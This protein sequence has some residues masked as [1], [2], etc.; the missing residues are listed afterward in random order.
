MTIYIGSDHRGFAI[1]ANTIQ[2]LLKAGH[3]VVDVGPYIYN[4]NDDYVGYAIK[5]S[6]SVQNNSES[7][8]ILI[9]GSGVGMYIV[10]NK[11]KGIRAAESRSKAEAIHDRAHHNSNILVLGQESIDNSQVNEIIET[12]LNTKFEGGR[13]TRRLRKLEIL[14]EQM[15]KEY[16]KTK[17]I[18][19]VLSDNLDDYKFRIKEFSKFSKVVNIDIED[20]NFVVEK[21]PAIKEIM[22]LTESQNVYFT[23]H[24]MV[25]DPQT[26]IEEL[27]SYSNISTVYVHAESLTQEILQ[28]ELPFDIAI[29]VSDFT[30]V[31]DYADLYPF[32]TIAQV[33]TVP[34]GKKGSKFISEQLKKIE[35][36]RA[37]GFK[38]EIHIDGS[39]NDETLPDIMKYH[40]E[41]LNVDSAILKNDLFEEN[42]N[43]MQ[44]LVNN[45]IQIQK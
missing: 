21:T 9:C 6:Q 20:G 34:L 27:K 39:V 25:S 36:L 10:A 16:L 24:L 15:T 17:I 45:L 26:C 12:W 31:K 33:M 35:E 19:V 13:H 8:G 14:E 37:L 2:F 22:E 1:K 32:C 44:S 23:V 3:T 11:F 30:D 28:E 41:I 38:G 7:R 42:F 43:R 5:V 40:P 18:P 29:V 4:K